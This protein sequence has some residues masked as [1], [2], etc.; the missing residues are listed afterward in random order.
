[1]TENLSTE[2]LR[3]LQQKIRQ[4]MPGSSEGAIEAAIREAIGCVDP[5]E[6]P[7]HKRRTP[8]PQYPRFSET[9]KKSLQS[10]DG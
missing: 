5:V 1:M 3:Q 9:K 4:R 2:K 8:A 7:P 10:G 6:L